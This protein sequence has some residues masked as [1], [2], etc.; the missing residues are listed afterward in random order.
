MDAADAT[1][2]DGT[3]VVFTMIGA[4]V[5][6]AAIFGLLLGAVIL[7]NR[8]DGPLPRAVLGPV[9]FEI[10]PISMAVYGVVMVG[11][12]LLVGLFLV[13]AVSHRYVE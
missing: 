2:T 7:P 1:A 5:S 12:V 13:R 11:A 8:V 3:N 10:T 4:L 6:V 9:S